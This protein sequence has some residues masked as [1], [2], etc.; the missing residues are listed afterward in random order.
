MNFNAVERI[1]ELSEAGMLVIDPDRER[2]PHLFRSHRFTDEEIA[3]HQANYKPKPTYEYG[4]RGNLQAEDDELHGFDNSVPPRYLPVAGEYKVK[5]RAALEEAGWKV[6]RNTDPV[7]QVQADT[8]IDRETGEIVDKRS[9]RATGGHIHVAESIS[10]RALRTHALIAGCAPTERDFIRYVLKMRSGRGGFLEPL[11]EMLDRWVVHAH[12]G[13]D[14]SN[15]A[16]KRRALRTILYKRA[17][18]HDDQTLTRGFQ[19][20]RRN[21]KRDNLGEASRAALVLPMKAKPA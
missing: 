9:V 19:L 5:P 3:E 14:S 17:I 21:T 16:R 18:L 7:Y 10:D 13:M 6:G 15:R 8:W 20:L 2:Y 12:P 4:T 11:S 1:K